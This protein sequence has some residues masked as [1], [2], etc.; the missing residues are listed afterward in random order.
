MK[1]RNLAFVCLAAG[2]AALG[3]FFGAIVLAIYGAL[4]L[5]LDKMAFENGVWPHLF[6]AFGAL[7]GV[8]LAWGI[9]RLA[10]LAAQRRRRAV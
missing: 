1:P 10:D 8:A 6:G 3:Y 7:G 9:L 4:A 5:G 2:L